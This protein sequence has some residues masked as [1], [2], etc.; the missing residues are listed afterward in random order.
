MI[1]T[2]RDLKIANLPPNYKQI[3]ETIPPIKTS[4][5]LLAFAV[6]INTQSKESPETVHIS[7]TN[8]YGEPF[9]FEMAK[10]NEIIGDSLRKFAAAYRIKE[11]ERGDSPQASQE[12]KELGLEHHSN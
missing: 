9:I 12:I 7:G 1:P 6:P 5:R 4:Q 10:K 3:P 8:A 2:Y 11:L